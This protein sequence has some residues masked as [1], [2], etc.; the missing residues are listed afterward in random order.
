MR[1]KKRDSRTKVAKNVLFWR[2]K[3]R[4]QAMQVEAKQRIEEDTI[5]LERLLDKVA[6]D[7]RRRENLREKIMKVPSIPLSQLHLV[8]DKARYLINVDL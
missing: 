3:R 7:K 1:L 6:E 5:I 4:S 8:V 2:E